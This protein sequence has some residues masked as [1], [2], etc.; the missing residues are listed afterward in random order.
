MS[1]E[2]FVDAD[3]AADFLSVT[4]RRLLDMVRAEKITGHPL[5]HGMR[6]EWRFRLSELE[7]DMEEGKTSFD[8]SS[9]RRENGKS[10]KPGKGQ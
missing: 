4:R 6:R 7:K 10:R 9:D 1:P 8:S 2:K 5:D 3:T